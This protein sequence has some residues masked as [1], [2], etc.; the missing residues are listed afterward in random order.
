MSCRFLEDVLQNVCN[1]SFPCH[2]LL[3]SCDGSQSRVSAR[4]SMNPKAAANSSAGP[5]LF[6]TRVSTSSI[7]ACGIVGAHVVGRGAQTIGRRS[8]ELL[9]PLPTR[10]VVRSFV[11]GGGGTFESVRRHRWAFVDLLGCCT[12]HVRH[13]AARALSQVL[14]KRRCRVR[15]RVICRGVLSRHVLLLFLM[16]FASGAS[17]V[18]RVRFPSTARLL[19]HMALHRRRID[20]PA[21]VPMFG[22]GGDEVGTRSPFYP[23]GSP[24]TTPPPPLHSYRSPSPPAPS[25]PPPPSHTPLPP[26][27]PPPPP[28]PP[29]L[30]PPPPSPPLPF[31]LSLSSPLPLPSSL[32]FSYPFTPRPLAFFP[33]SPP[34]HLFSPLPSCALSTANRSLSALSIPYTYLPP[35]TSSRLPLSL[36]HSRPSHSPPSLAVGDPR[37]DTPSPPASQPSAARPVVRDG[38]P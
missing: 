34:S 25:P 27:P 8:G 18:R 21:E 4:P 32:F 23:P 35:T 6:F 10:E 2:G 14:A 9:H 17:C 26:P 36:D 15:H 19:E 11:D 5:G 24:P 29:P 31:R 3:P 12:C 38:T 33:V 37:P 16:L 30:P 28:L 1:R 13:R 7:I 22:D 20:V